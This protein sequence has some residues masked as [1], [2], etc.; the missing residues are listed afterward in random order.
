MFWQWS[1]GVTQLVERRT[2]GS[3]GPEVR[4][5]HKNEFFFSQTYCA[6]SLSVSPINPR[7]AHT[8]THYKNDHART[9]VKDPVVHVRVWWTT[10]NTKRSNVH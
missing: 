10:E 6:D 2:Q 1:D 7:V 9:H 4:T 3:M 8:L 5:P